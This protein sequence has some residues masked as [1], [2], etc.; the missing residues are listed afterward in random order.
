VDPEQVPVLIVGA[1]GGGLSLALLLLQQGIHPLVVERRP[2]ISWYP[3]ARN[4]N[5]R[6]MEVFRG[7]GLSNEIHAA[8]ARVSRIFARERLASR[9]QKEVM[10]PS[11]LL[12]TE[13]LSPE[14]FIWYCPQSRLEPILLAAARE[15]GADIRYSTEVVGFAQV[16]HGV[17]ATLQDRSTRASHVVHAQ[18]LV[19]ADGAHSRVREALHI[20]T[21]GKGTLDEHY[22]FVYF[23]AA[24]DQLVRGHETDVFLIEN[25]DVRGMLVIAEKNLG[26]FILSQRKAAEELTRERAQELL[27]QAIGQR[28]IAVEVIE[29]APWQ[30]EQRV[31]KWFQQG[32]VFLVGDAA[33][34]MPP[35]EGLGVNTAIQSAQNLAWKLAAVLGGLAAP[36]LLSTYQTE[37][38]PVAWFAA[39][40]SMT[41]P[42]AAV[43]EN[44]RMNDKASEFFP[45]VGYRYRS[46][47]VLSE[48]G[49]PPQSEIVLLDREE[50]TGLPGTRVPHIWLERRSQRISTLD[51][52]DGRFVLLSG[53]D[54]ARWCEEAAR[55]T[56]SLGIN[57]VAAYRIGADGELRDPE[58]GWAQ[59]M[60][61]S[62]DGAVLVR[63][64]GFVAWRSHHL[65]SPPHQLEQVLSRILCR[66]AATINS[67]T[68][69]MAS[70]H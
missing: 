70:K 31:A 13:A 34:T 49:L 7:L 35:K 21:E 60:G 56:T 19:G 25:P 14:P 39:K 53:S 1:G 69:E 41:G 55:A 2:D 17:T 44:T 46:R 20:P 15:R 68:S 43:L 8:G 50:L 58:H 10:D 27:T 48:D 23:R 6:T 26:M 38:H 51:L 16:E 67:P 18:F 61:V 45:I 11:S 40:H 59:R 32:H 30:P 42:A 62:S 22:V 52:L 65:T 47:A 28:E 5:F 3:R 36:E 57:L 12:D 29:V 54:S 33:H 37:R 63:P 9:Q 66:S 24:L 4:L 64:D